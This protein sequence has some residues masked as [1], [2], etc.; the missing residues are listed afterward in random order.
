MVDL[1]VDGE[2]SRFMVSRLV[3]QHFIRDLAADDCVFHRDLDKKNN[4]A[5]NLLVTTFAEAQR[6]TRESLFDFERVE[7][8]EMTAAKAA[9]YLDYRD[10]RLFWKKRTAACVVVGTE[11]GFAQEGHWRVSFLGNVYTRNQ[12]V[13]L[14]HHGRT[15][16][17]VLPR[18]GDYMDSR[19]ENLCAATA[20]EWATISGRREN[21]RP[22]NT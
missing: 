7:R 10:G 3:A 19:I 5:S 14:I 1:M 12:L 4:R 22:P 9:E 6:L 18:N 11:A 2:R 8:S 16:D 21:L 15:P 17:F 20:S 13:Y